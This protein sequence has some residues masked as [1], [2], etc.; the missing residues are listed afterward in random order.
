MPAF[1]RDSA[2]LNK[3]PFFAPT[4][5]PTIMATGVASPKA[6]GQLITRTEIPLARAKPKVLP[7]ASHTNVVTSAIAI[8]IGTNTPETLSAI[9]A[10]GAFV[11]EA[12]LTILI[13]WESVV[14]SPTFVALHFIKPD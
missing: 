13:I 5:E 6:Q 7:T 10:T 14:S 4:P 8:T 2:V 9:F 3:I 12:S 1:S 11:A